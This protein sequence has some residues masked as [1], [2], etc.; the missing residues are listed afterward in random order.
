MEASQPIVVL[1]SEDPRASHRANEALRIALGIV[2]G[3]NQLTVILTG[4]AAH[5]LD[6]D[7]DDLVDGEDIAR[8]R[9][10]LRKL[11]VLFHVEKSAIPSTGDAWNEERLPFVLVSGE[12]IAGLMARGRSFIVF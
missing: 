11:G 5:L 7:T 4:P 12:E 6:S 2:A 3:E 1:I 10:A 9:A 8:H